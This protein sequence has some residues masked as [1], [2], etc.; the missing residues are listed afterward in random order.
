MLSA[1]P[2]YETSTGFVR[3][4]QPDGYSCG[5]TSLYAILMHHNINIDFFEL[6][7]L[8]NLTKDGSLD[9]DLVKAA[10]ALGCICRYRDNS[11][12]TIR[13]EISSGRP[14]LCTRFDVPGYEEDGHFSVIHGY[15]DKSIL[16]AD[17]SF[18][19]SH[20]IPIRKIRWLIGDPILCIRPRHL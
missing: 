4:L 12:V 15:T 6:R 1:I 14:I 18:L 7:D 9:Y 17:P 16:M 10:R 3:F 11:V 5:P 20:K 8:C 19:G 2:F 13:E